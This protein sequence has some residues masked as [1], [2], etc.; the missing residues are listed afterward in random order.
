M[1]SRLMSSGTSPSVVKCRWDKELLASST[2]RLPLASMASR[3]ALPRAR[4]CSCMTST[5]YQAA[6]RQELM[7]TMGLSQAG[8][9]MWD[10][11]M[12]P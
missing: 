10:D 12:V 5:E 2:A 9:V 7:L 8:L 1:C 11:T 3:V 6:L 4:A